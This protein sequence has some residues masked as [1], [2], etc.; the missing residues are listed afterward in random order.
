MKDY[1]ALLSSSICMPRMNA[2][3]SMIHQLSYESA[4]SNIHTRNEPVAQNAAIPVDITVKEGFSN[5][6]TQG[7]VRH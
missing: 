2:M 5:E 6:G 1:I 7:V 3:R 4:R